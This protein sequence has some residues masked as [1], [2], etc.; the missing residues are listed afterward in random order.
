VVHLHDQI[1]GHLG[2][3]HF[4]AHQRFRHQPIWAGITR[5]VRIVKLA[6]RV[7]PSPRLPC[8]TTK[9]LPAIDETGG[10]IDETGGEMVDGEC[11]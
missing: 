6:N 11:S 1:S 10:D 9:T 5:G 4:A 3:W 8:S 7:T 2:Q